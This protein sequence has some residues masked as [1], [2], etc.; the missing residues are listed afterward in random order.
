M[1]DDFNLDME[2]AELGLEDEALPE[3]AGNR[4]FLLVAGILGG[5]L[6]LSMICIAVYAM[7]LLPRSQAQRSTQVAEINAQNTQ[8]AMASKLTAE[9][10]AWTATPT[11]TQPPPTATASPTPVIAPT[12]TPML[13]EPTQD[14]RT[15]TVAALLTMQAGG[16]TTITPTVTALPDTGFMDDIGVPGLLIMAAA[17]ILVI[18]LARRLRLTTR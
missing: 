13:E 1:M 7:V 5:V 2:D 3:E 6:I 10:Q 9:A 4:T 8:V 11:N 18:L 16:G 17:L 15:A 12:D 14:P